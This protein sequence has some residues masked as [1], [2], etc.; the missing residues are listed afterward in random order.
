M[1]ERDH[2]DAFAEGLEDG[3]EAGVGDDGGGAF[4]EF[5]LRGVGDDDW[6]AGELA[7]ARGVE[8]SAKGEDEL[9]VEGGAGFSDG[10]EDGFG[11]V[12][13]GSEGGVDEGAAVE[14]VPGEVDGRALGAVDEGAGVVQDGV[15]V[16][17]GELEG[18]G[19]LGDLGEG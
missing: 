15:E 11:A 13:E 2:G 18:A 12:L 8:A 3:V 14:A 4:D 19:E 17:D 5:E 16:F 9:R 10:F 1:W 6:V 7:E